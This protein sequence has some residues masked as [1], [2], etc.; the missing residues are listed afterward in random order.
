MAM[1]GTS[2]L[3]GSSMGRQSPDLAVSGR[4]GLLALGAVLIVAAALGGGG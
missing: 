2:S 3:S 1:P 4:S